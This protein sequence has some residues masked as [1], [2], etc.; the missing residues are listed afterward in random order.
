VRIL[1]EG[2]A[3]VARLSVYGTE[4]QRDLAAR[5]VEHILRRAEEAGKE[6]YEKAR[7]IIE[8]GMSRC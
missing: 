1:R 4:G 3:H 2:L 8:E 6:V 5:F 7:E